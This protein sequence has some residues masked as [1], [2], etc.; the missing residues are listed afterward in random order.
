VIRYSEEQLRFIN[1]PDSFFVL[2]VLAFAGAGKTTVLEAYTNRRLNRRF[3]YLAFNSDIVKEAK[4]RFNSRNTDVFTG[5]GLAYRAIGFHYKD[6]L[7]GD[8]S[9]TDVGEVLISKFKF[10]RDDLESLI[11][12]RLAI[13]VVKNY[14]S[15]DQMEIN[16]THIDEHTF[17]SIART[18]LSDVNV[19]DMATVIWNTM[20]DPA[21]TSIPMIHD[22]YLK[23]YQIAGI[24]LDYDY[25]IV[26]EAQDSTKCVLAILARQKAKLIMVGDPHQ[27]I[28]LFRGSSNAFEYFKPCYTFFLTKSYRFGETTAN[29]GNYVL[30]T[31]RLMLPPIVGMGED[32]YVRQDEILDSGEQFM[33]ISRSTTGMFM[34]LLKYRSELMSNPKREDTW[35]FIGGVKKYNFNVIISAMYLYL[36]QKDKVWSSEIKAF[37]SW[38][39]YSAYATAVNDQK[40]ISIVKLVEKLKSKVLP[41]LMGFKSMHVDDPKK[42]SIL[43]TTG[44]RSK[45]LEHDNVVVNGDFLLPELPDLKGRQPDFDY[46]QVEQETNLTYVACT[47]AK[48]RIAI[49][50]NE[51]KTKPPIIPIKREVA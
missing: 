38:G 43:L 5:H 1:A 25:I 21:D 10:I 18:G 23:L 41:I 3:L 6:Q 26:D 12:A 36:N 4:K 46:K 16:G 24:E 31:K 49:L 29:I 28:Y 40:A 19:L 34:L 14:L 8:L 11:Y 42:A 50:G 48:K 51:K 33:S 30:G 45:G 9:N 27:S 32:E 13:Q 17:G 47:R 39:E 2:F 15:C 20:C 22:G 35:H 44:H 37:G 7:E